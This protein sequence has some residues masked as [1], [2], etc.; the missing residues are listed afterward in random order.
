MYMAKG[1][2]VLITFLDD[3]G[4]TVRRG[5]ALLDLARKQEAALQPL[6]LGCTAV[7]LAAAL[8]RATSA[9]L[10]FLLQCAPGGALRLDESDIDADA[11]RCGQAE[12]NLEIRI[13]RLPEIISN[14]LLTIHHS[15]VHGRAI[16]EMISYRNRF[17]HPTDSVRTTELHPQVN[18]NGS[19]S[20]NV[21]IDQTVDDKW[22]TLTL[23][24]GERFL[25]AVRIYFQEVIGK[26]T[27]R[28]SFRAGVLL[29]VSKRH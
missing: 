9:A 2:S 17:A 23:A 11:V 26:V 22:E 28:E 25:G 21:P 20:V 19:I 13:R 6:L 1:D 18:E 14:E 3:G 10:D 16:G 15:N 12:R 27:K 7:V 29:S 5:S 4:K 8:D 24:H